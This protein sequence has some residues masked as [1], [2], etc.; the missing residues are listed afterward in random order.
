MQKLLIVLFVVGTFGLVAVAAEKPAESYQKAMKD[1][2]AFAAG[3]DKAIMTEDY[4]AA[5]KFAQSAK[6][7]FDVAA[8]YWKGRNT[9]AA[10]LAQKG[11]KAASDL[12]VTSGLKSQEG[13][14]YAVTEAKSVCMACHTAHRERLADGTFEIK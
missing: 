9:E 11:S 14:A 5:A 1:L 7:A 4:D 10:A 6:D 12:L 2:G 8:T 13:A 3:I